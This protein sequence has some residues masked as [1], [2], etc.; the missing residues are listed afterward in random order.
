MPAG[1]WRYA[2]RRRPGGFPR[3][4]NK[5]SNDIKE[6]LAMTQ[7]DN[8]QA[9]QQSPKPNPTTSSRPLAGP[10]TAAGP[11]VVSDANPRYFAVAT[12]KSGNAGGKVVYLTGS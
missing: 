7:N 2:Y 8:A 10:G 1:R 3:Y 11:L 9:S 6:K 4:F 5:A 12:G